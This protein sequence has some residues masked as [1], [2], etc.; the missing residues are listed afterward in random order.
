[1]IINIKNIFKMSQSLKEQYLSATDNQQRQILF[2]NYL[3]TLPCIMYQKFTYCY[4]E[5]LMIIKECMMIEDVYKIIL[6]YLINTTKYPKEFLCK[7]TSTSTI[8]GDLSVG[9][10]SGVC[11]SAYYK[12]QSFYYY[13][14]PFPENKK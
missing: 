10:C 6:R 13:L 2:K 14:Y 7:K 1:M 4:L 12:Y 9:F 8:W 3:N 5:R 11:N